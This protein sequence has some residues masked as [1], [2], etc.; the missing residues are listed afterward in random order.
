MHLQVHLLYGEEDLVL[1]QLPLEVNGELATGSKYVYPSEV[2]LLGSTSLGALSVTI[3]ACP[4][5]GALKSYQPILPLSDGTFPTIHLP[6]PG[7][8]LLR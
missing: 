1:F 4:L 8:E 6:L 3:H 7:E 2:V 5:K